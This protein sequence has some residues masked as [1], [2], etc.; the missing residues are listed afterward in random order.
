MKIWIWLQPLLSKTMVTTVPFNNV[1][2]VGSE[3]FVPLVVL[4]VLAWVFGF[5]TVLN[6]QVLLIKT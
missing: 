6:V 3:E 1:T 2:V 5:Y 4:V